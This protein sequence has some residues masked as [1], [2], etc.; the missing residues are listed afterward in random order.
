MMTTACGVQ[1]SGVGD[2]KA[3]ASEEVARKVTGD[4]TPASRDLA[5]VEKTKPAAHATSSEGTFTRWSAEY[6]QGRHTRTTRKPGVEGV[7]G[8]SRRRDPG[9]DGGEHKVDTAAQQVPAECAPE[10]RNYGRRSYVYAVIRSD[11]RTLRWIYFIQATVE[12]L[13]YL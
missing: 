11:G 9:V 10:R 3:G 6:R 2:G 7:E 4:Q 13:C 8:N 1:P 12:K 5:R